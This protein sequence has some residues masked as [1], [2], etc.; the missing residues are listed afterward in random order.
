M[1]RTPLAAGLAGL[2][3][4]LLAASGILWV[5]SPIPASLETASFQGGPDSPP[6]ER[7]RA[8]FVT[9]GCIGC[10]WHEQAGAPRTS[11]YGAGPDLSKIEDQYT[12]L[13]NDLAYVRTWLRS[14]W[15]KNPNRVMPNPNLSD[16]KIEDLLAFLVPGASR[17]AQP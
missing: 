4:A 7:G 12:L 13:H 5:G 8:L 10:H 1:R 15:V 11:S 14:P 16:D 17:P 9:E 3:A 6:Y 2:G